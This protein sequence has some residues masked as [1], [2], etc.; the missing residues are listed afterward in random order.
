VTKSDIIRV[1]SGFSPRVDIS[2]LRLSF[3]IGSIYAIIADM[4]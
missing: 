3:Q 4:K 1:F 2:A